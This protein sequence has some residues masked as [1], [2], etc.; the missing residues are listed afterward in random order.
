MDDSSC[1]K[2]AGFT[3]EHIRNGEVVSTHIIPTPTARVADIATTERIILLDGDN[4]VQL[5]DE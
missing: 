4:D 3:I 5:R 1:Y 2:F